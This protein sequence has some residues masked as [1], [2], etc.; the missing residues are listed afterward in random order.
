[1]EPLLEALRALGWNDGSAVVYGTLVESGAMKPADLVVKAGVAQGK[2]YTV[3]DELVQEGFAVKIGDRPAV[4]DAQHPRD[5]LNMAF[6]RLQKSKDRA[7][8][9]AEEAYEHRYD[10]RAREAACEAVRGM[11]GIQIQLTSLVNS[12][13]TSIRIADRNL[14]WLVALAGTL[15]EKAVDR[16]VQV[17]GPVE[18]RAVLEELGAGGPDGSMKQVEAFCLDGEVEAFCVIDDDTVLV[19]FESPDCAMCVRDKNFARPYVDKFES[20]LAKGK[21]VEVLQIAP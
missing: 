5:V 8:D 7:I 9:A 12:C 2:I 10:Q 11:G 20:Y 13:A 19:R 6:D 4:Y 3:L 21:K 1:M 15:G 14:R 17:A 18:A 16:T